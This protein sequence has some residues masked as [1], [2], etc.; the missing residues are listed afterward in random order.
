MEQDLITLER[1]LLLAE[2]R[3]QKGEVG[4][5]QKNGAYYAERMNAAVDDRSKADDELRRKDNEISRLQS[6]LNRAVGCMENL[7]NAK[8]A[9]DRNAAKRGLELFIAHNRPQPSKPE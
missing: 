8:G 1:E 9:K 3:Y 2:I 4:R 7:L 5:A 6:V